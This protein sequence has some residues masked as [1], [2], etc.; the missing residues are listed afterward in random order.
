VQFDVYR[1]P[2]GGARAAF[3][4]VVILQADGAATG[5][6]RLVAPLAPASE[7]GAAPGRLIP[8]VLV[9]G[10]EHAVLVPQLTPLRARLLR[11]RV[12]SAARY[13]EPLLNAVDHL[14]FGF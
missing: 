13:R 8:R 11:E 6:D 4:Y 5:T 3:P 1:N 14:F 7:L 10:V 12:D 2:I 9:G